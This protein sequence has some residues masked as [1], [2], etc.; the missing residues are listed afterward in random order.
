MPSLETNY[1][2]LSLKNP[3]IAASSGLTKTI[4]NV[5]ACEKSGVGAVVLK[6]LFEE[7]LAEDEWNA[8]K[9]A[10]RH[11]EVFDYLRSE[12][13]FQ[14]GIDAYCHLIEQ[15]KKEVDIPIIASINGTSFKWLLKFA[16][17]VE[18]AGAD[19]LELNVYLPRIN[20]ATTAAQIETAYFDILEKVKAGISIPVSMKIGMYFSSLPEFAQQ[21]E[22]RGLDALVMF[23]RFTEPEIDI[24]K[25]SVH[26]T[27]SLSSKE[28]I[29]RLLRW[30]A[31]V[32]AKT[33]LEIS[34]T[35]GVHSYEGVIKLL[36]AGATTVQLASLLYGKGLG[37]IAILLERMTAWMQRHNFESPDQFR[38]ILSFSE[39]ENAGLYL[40]AQFMEKIRAME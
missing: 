2:G 11:P 13:R 10:A 24:E 27:F 23:N 32:S 21:L 5:K 29:N 22:Y 25:I 17:R 36:L 19:A 38:G 1:M 8:G 31:I 15:A 7:V 12:L 16:H 34:A 33:N 39:A 18:A 6:S 20:E 4:E 9:N 3:I 28:D 35:G 26:T 30:T 37:E 40:R 14:Y